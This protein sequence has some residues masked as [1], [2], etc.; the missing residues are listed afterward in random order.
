MDGTM[1][2]LATLN[3]QKNG[4]TITPITDIT[5]QAESV[6]PIISDEVRSILFVI[7]VKGLQLIFASFGI[8]SNMVNIIVY[9]K[10]GFSETSSITMTALSL[11]DLFTELWLLLMAA[12]LHVRFEDGLPLSVTIMYL[13]S[14]ASNAVLGYGSWIT[15]IISAERCLCIVFPMFFP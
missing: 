1:T 12:S 10:M 4:Q 3:V 6:S 15:A 7:L 8:F 9:I 2:P 11:A 5:V 14:T 13:L